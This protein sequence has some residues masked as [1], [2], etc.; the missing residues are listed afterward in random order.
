MKKTKIVCSIGPA[1]SSVDVMKKMVDAGMNVARINFSH[2][3][4]EQTDYVLDTIKEVRKLTGQHVAIL[5]DTKGP[6]FRCGIMQEGGVNLVNGNFIRI[7]KDDVIGNEERFSVNCPAALDKINEGNIILLEDALMKLQVVSKESD[8]ITCV[9]VDGGVLDSK[10]GINVPGVKLGLPFMSEQDVKDIQYACE[11]DGDFLALSFVE[12]KENILEARALLRNFGREDM[13]IISKVESST[14]LDNLDDIISLSD[15]IMVARGDLGVEVPIQELPIIQKDMIKRCRKTGRFVIVATEMLASMYTSSRPTRAEVTDI[16]NAVLDGT[17]AVMLSG[18]ST[19][20]K[21]PIEAVKFMASICEETEKYS[22]EY[23][24]LFTP[25]KTSDI[26]EA[27]AEA[28][29]TSVSSLDV[30]SIVVPTTG[31]HSAMVMSNLRPSPMIL[32]ICPNER[33]AKRLAISYGVYAKVVNV[34][35]NNMDLVVHHCKEEAKEFLSLKEKDIIII[36]GGIHDNPHIKQT[37][38]LKIEEI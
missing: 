32:A 11:H 27:I 13:Q 22:S 36:T 5:Y 20:G 28:V 4:Y 37:N 30:K 3:T 2:A 10:K 1:S 9:V 17:D 25:V 18:E 23:S 26:T 33:V 24:S 6:D 29:L 15:G 34:D 8:G 7:V 35:D 19:V 38:F 12:C 31:G 16:S 14:A 21:H